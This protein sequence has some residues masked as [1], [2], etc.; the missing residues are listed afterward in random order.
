MDDV[1]AGFKSFNADGF[2]RIEIVDDDACGFKFNC[3]ACVT[4]ETDVKLDV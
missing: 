1:A 2:D 3:E 4:V